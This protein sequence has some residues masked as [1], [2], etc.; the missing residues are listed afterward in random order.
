[1]KYYYVADTNSSTVERRLIPLKPSYPIKIEGIH[2][3]VKH[4]EYN[5]D[6]GFKT[7]K[8]ALQFLLMFNVNRVN[9][10]RFMINKIKRQLK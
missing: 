10:H 9:W 5:T 1:M 8:Q 4:S 6:Y 7:R 3:I 2:V